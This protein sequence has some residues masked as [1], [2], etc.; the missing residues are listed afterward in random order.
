MNKGKYWNLKDL[1]TDYASGYGLDRNELK[2]RIQKAYEE[3]KISGHEYDD[4]IQ[5]LDLEVE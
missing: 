4:L 2:G 3:N 1:I 5:Y